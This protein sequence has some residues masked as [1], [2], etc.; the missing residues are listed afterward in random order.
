MKIS[1]RD[2]ILDYRA[3]SWASPQCMSI[4]PSLMTGATLVFAKKF[5][6]TRFPS[7]L[8]GHG[9]TISIGVPAV[10]NMLL[11]EEVPL[12]KR[13]VPALRFM[14]SSTAPL[15]VKNLFRFEE[16]YGIPINQLAG[17]SECGVVCV[18][19]PENLNYPEKRKIGSIGNGSFKIVSAHLSI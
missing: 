19:D 5:S 1:E 12:H 9:I 3:Y 15:M 6:R 7:W 11:E 2:I 10:F 17:S 18:N 8:K 14:T 4:L 16:I 13:D